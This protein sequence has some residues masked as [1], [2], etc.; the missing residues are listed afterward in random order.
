MSLRPQCSDLQYVVADLHTHA[1]T[2][3]GNSHHR[4]CIQCDGDY[5]E[6]ERPKSLCARYLS[7]SKRKGTCV[8]G[9]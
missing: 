1:D 7:C 8:V 3:S 5:T 9:V 4:D 6:S 2:I